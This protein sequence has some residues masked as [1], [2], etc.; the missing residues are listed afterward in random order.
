VK[1][2]LTIPIEFKTRAVTANVF[3]FFAVRRIM[4]KTRP[5]KK[6]VNGRKILTA[7]STSWPIYVE[8]GV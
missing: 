1:S 4:L 2:P 3:S 6:R 5:N 7:V 8:S